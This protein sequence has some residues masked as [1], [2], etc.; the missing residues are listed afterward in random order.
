MHLVC[1]RCKP[2]DGVLPAELV[3]QDSR[4]HQAL[5]SQRGGTRELLRCCI[6]QQWQQRRRWQRRRYLHTVP[7]LCSREVVVDP[8]AILVGDTGWKEAPVILRACLKQTAN[9]AD[10][11][12]ANRDDAGAGSALELRAD[13]VV[14]KRTATIL[15][16]DISEQLRGVE[17]GGVVGAA[18]LDAVEDFLQ[19]RLA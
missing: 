2:D 19:S 8:L 5:Q 13:V 14:L 9:Q 15:S 4:G 16:P 7:P 11:V 10:W 18:L 12:L 6:A 17:R 3:L 1:P